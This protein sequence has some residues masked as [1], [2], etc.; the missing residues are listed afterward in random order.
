MQRIAWLLQ[1]SGVN[2]K[3]GGVGRIQESLSSLLFKSKPQT[4]DLKL[5]VQINEV[6]P[7]TSV[8]LEFKSNRGGRACIHDIFRP[9][10]FQSQMVPPQMLRHN[11]CHNNKAGSNFASR[12]C[13]D[14]IPIFVYFAAK[15]FC[16]LVIFKLCPAEWI[17]RQEDKSN[18]VSNSKLC[19]NLWNQILAWPVELELVNCKK[20]LGFN[21]GV[22]IKPWCVTIHII[23]KVIDHS[24]N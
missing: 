1:C 4:R 19:R 3:E 2:R 5:N 22:W 18:A 20:L 23:I 13:Q 6:T 12:C 16:Y 24:L 10:P 7:V 14:C 15:R 21:F 11:S 8:S 9:S 17:V